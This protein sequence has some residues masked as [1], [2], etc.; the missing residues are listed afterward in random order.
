[1]VAEVRETKT[2]QDNSK[3]DRQS[4]AETENKPAGTLS[5]G[6]EGET[7]T[8]KTKIG[9]DNSKNDRQSNTETENKPVGTLSLDITGNRPSSRQRKAPKLLSK[10]FLW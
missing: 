10:D 3:I 6:I 1:M 2:G 5:L 7:I 8:M 9:Q 4:N